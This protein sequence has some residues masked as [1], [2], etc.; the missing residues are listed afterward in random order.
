MIE[1]RGQGLA[2]PLDHRGSGL[3]GGERRRVGIAR[4][5]LKDAPLWLLDEPY[6]NLDRPGHVLVDRMLE[7]H[8]QR[9]GSA[10]L[11]SHGLSMPA[12]ARVG[13]LQLRVTPP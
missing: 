2:L 12:L 3:S 9:G 7:T 13:R 8:C 10:I 6:A 4:V 5:L 11:T 1:A